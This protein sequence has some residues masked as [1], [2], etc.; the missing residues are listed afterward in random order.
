MPTSRRQVPSGQNPA[1]AIRRVRGMG[2]GVFAGRSFDTGELI[3]VCPVLVLPPEAATTSTDGLRAYVFLWGAA[4][5][6]L[7]IALGYGSL[8]NHSPNPNAEFCPHHGRGEIQFWCLRR[9]AA[10][11]QILI[12]YQWNPA[13]YIGFG[14]PAHRPECDPH[15]A[16]IPYRLAPATLTKNGA[17]R[18]R[19]STGIV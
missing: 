9:I 17:R 18:S 6:R 14:V 2:R 7:A 13:D 16:P 19:A 10:G 1:L 12:D 5:D 3:E 4:G 11:E 15:S 8:Y